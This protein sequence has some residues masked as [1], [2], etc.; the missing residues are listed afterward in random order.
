[1]TP[2]R[3]TSGASRRLRRACLSLVLVLLAQFF[4]G[5]VTNLYVRVSPRHPGAHAA[6]YFSGVLSGVGWAIGH[7]PAALV[8]HAT[9]GLLLAGASLATLLITI[10][11]G[12][13]VEMVFAA[14][15]S[16]AVI[17][18]GFNGASFLNYGHNLSSLIMTGLALLAA[19]AYT[20]ILY[21]SLNES[22]QP[23]DRPGFVTDGDTRKK[24]A[25][26]PVTGHP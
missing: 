11:A 14:L 23:P 24:S 15:G 1:M 10:R 4:V 6:E 7:G 19:A 26:M 13:R 5:M 21:V 18:A 17:G 2:R 16:A 25:S 9:L 22:Q 20:A 8:L 3:A 12:Q